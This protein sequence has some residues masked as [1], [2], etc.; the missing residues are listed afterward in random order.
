MC[1]CE[2]VSVGGGRVECGRVGG[3]ECVRVCVS[4]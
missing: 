1:V 3:W 2:G 4:V